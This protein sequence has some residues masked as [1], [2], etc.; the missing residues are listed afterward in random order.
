MAQPTQ[1][2]QLLALKE[3]ATLARRSYA[4]AW[5]RAD[6]GRLDV[7]RIGCRI[8]VTEE[9]LFR[10]IAADLARRRRARKEPARLRLVVD[11]T[12]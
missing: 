5:E 8:M 4:W 10:A 11:N 6:D 1:R 3:A 7:V 9:S 12:K 2:P